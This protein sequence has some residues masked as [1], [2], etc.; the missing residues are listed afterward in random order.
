ML[1][2]LFENTFR[3]SLLARS[4][5]LEWHFKALTKMVNHISIHQLQRPTASFTAHELMELI[6]II[7]SDGG[8]LNDKDAKVVCESIG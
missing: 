5:S 8:E 4:G 3:K 6:E 1:R 2:T 7:L